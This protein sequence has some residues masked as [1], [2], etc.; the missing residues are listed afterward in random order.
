M[1]TARNFESTRHFLPLERAFF[2]WYSCFAAGNFLRGRKR[3]LTI[4]RSTEKENS[5]E[6]LYL[7]PPVPPGT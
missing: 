1:P 4:S 6:S 3:R 2:S 5:R 7:P